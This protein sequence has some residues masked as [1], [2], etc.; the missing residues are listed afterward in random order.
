MQDHDDLY[1]REATRLKEELSQVRRIIKDEHQSEIDTLTRQHSLEKEETERQNASNCERLMNELKA[2]KDEAEK[3]KSAHQ[4]EL[5][6]FQNVAKQEAADLA[7]ELR[8]AQI[9]IKSLAESVEI[10]RK[11][12]NESR[13]AASAEMI[14]NRNV[15]TA[16]GHELDRARSLQVSSRDETRQNLTKILD[17][18]LKKLNTEF[19]EPETETQSRLKRFRDRSHSRSMSADPTADLP[20]YRAPKNILHRRSVSPSNFSASPSPFVPHRTLSPQLT[21]H[22]ELKRLQFLKDQMRHRLAFEQAHT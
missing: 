18:E 17:D 13:V 22:D 16:L 19:V 6:E 1:R 11:L 8:N 2:A 4:K 15:E 9:E 20:T 5:N 21:R 10:A 3:L 12:H 7:A 14:A